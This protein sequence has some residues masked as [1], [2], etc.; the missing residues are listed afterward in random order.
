MNFMCPFKID[1]SYIVNI[2]AI[3]P[4]HILVEHEIEKGF[5]C[6]SETVPPTGLK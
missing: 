6:R 1:V 2:K 3:R 5:R 4:N